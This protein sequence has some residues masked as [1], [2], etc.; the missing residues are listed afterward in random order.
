LGE[1]WHV[2]LP[3]LLMNDLRALPGVENVRIVY[4]NE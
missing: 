4:A 1:A 3:D 2:S